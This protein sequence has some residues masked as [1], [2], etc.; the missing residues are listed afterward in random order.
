MY[1]KYVHP[2]YNWHNQYYIQIDENTLVDSSGEY[3][4]LEK[5][6]SKVAKDLES[7]KNGQF[8]TVVDTYGFLESSKIEFESKVYD[9][10]KDLKVSITTSEMTIKKIQSLTGVFL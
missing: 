2:S 5:I 3:H 8:E 6:S 9:T 1:K 7:V 10:L 4:S